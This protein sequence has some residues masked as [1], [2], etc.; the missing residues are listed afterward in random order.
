MMFPKLPARK[1][2]RRQAWI[3]LRRVTIGELRQF[4]LWRDGGC[5]LARFGGDHVCRGHPTLEHVT[6]VHGH[7]DGRHD[8]EAHC[9]GLCLGTNI[10]HTDRAERLAIRDYLRGRYPICLSSPR[11]GDG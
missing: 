1:K 4:V 5:I 2:E 9:V 10:D 11:G 8:D 7:L 3:D 6:G